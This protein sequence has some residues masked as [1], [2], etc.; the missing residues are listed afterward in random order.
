MPIILRQNE[1]LI[2]VAR[3]HV[4][5]LM[6]VFFT[7]PLIVVALLI[8]RYFLHF[9]FFNYWNWTL[10][11]AILVVALIILYKYYIWL[12]NALIITNQRVVKNE[13]RGF[14]SQ[15][16]TELLYQD[17]LEISYSKQGMNAS[18]YDF[19][20]LQIRTAS[21]NQIIVEKIADPDGTVE[22]INKVRRVGLSPVP[23]GDGGADSPQSGEPSHV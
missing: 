3:Q 6:P 7:W 12:N 16:V 1:E 8:G 4:M 5:F 17:I 21:E 22:L 23:I 20:D 10:V 14:F 15:T 19:G 18:L 13:Q 2:K 9:D 11:F